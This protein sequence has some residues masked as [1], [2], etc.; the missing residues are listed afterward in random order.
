MFRE[1]KSTHTSLK[2]GALQQEAL[3]FIAMNIQF[4]WKMERL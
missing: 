2:I 4:S 3:G 1:M